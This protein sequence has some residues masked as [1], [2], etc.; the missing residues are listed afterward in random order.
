MHSLVLVLVVLKASII[1]YLGLVVVMGKPETRD[2]SPRLD[3]RG[4]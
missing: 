3:A 4:D 1:G 2:Q